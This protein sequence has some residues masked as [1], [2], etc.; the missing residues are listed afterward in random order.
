[1]VAVDGPHVQVLARLI[2]SP[3]GGDVDGYLSQAG[4]GTMP[5]APYNE[6]H[7][8]DA[9]WLALVKKAFTTVDKTARAALIAQAQKIEYDTGGYIIWAWRNQV[10]AYSK[11]T[12]GYKLD[13]LGGPVG[14]M[15]FKD[16][17][18]TA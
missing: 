17:Y 7:W 16:V 10:D 6:T 8:K 1:M 13:K 2:T 5:N 15:Y 3:V 12:T 14:R 9:Q 11:K 4:Q 18:F